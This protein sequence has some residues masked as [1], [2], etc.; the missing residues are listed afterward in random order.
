MRMVVGRLLGLSGD[1]MIVEKRESIQCEFVV[2]GRYLTF[3][4]SVPYHTDMTELKNSIITN[5]KQ[6]EHLKGT[7]LSNKFQNTVKMVRMSRNTPIL[8]LV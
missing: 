4:L 8:S 7:T 6:F 5:I 3:T 1:N 2:N